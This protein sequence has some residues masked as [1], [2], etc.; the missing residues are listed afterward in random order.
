MDRHLF[1]F[2]AGCA[3]DFPNMVKWHI[4]VPYLEQ[5]S[6]LS[7]SIRMRLNVMMWDFGQLWHHDVLA[8]YGT[9][10]RHHPP[11]RTMT[12]Q[13]RIWTHSVTSVTSHHWVISVRL[14]P[15]MGIPLVHFGYTRTLTSEGYVSLAYGYMYCK[16]TAGVQ[17][18]T[19]AFHHFHAFRQLF[20][21]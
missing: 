7:H 18:Y 2:C 21:L 19:Q 20:N 6:H 11:R 8:K 12:C 15:V 17:V 3:C 1:S 4:N 16:G 5:L 9:L 10:T 13:F 14:W